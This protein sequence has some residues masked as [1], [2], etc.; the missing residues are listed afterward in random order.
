MADI[1]A[2][3]A[4]DFARMIRFRPARDLEHLNRWRE[5]MMARPAAEAGI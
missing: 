5:A 2:I 3:T 4:I 1:L